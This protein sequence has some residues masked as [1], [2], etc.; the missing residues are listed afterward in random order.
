[1]VAFPD[2]SPVRSRTRE[3]LGNALLQRLGQKL[4]FSATDAW[5]QCSRTRERL[6]DALLQCLGQKLTFSATTFMA[7]MRGKTSDVEAL[8]EPERSRTAAVSVFGPA[9]ARGDVCGRVVLK[10][11]HR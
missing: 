4:T 3:R 9:A 7:P 6:G 2:P 8:H 1:M 5:S 10:V 11:R